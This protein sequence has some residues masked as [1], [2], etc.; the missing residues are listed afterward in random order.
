MLYKVHK[1]Q[2]G[3]A[4]IFLA[5]SLVILKFTAFNNLFKLQI[6]GTNVWSIFFTSFIIVLLSFGGRLLK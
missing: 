1:E 6:L 5:L 4:V 2:V 3:S